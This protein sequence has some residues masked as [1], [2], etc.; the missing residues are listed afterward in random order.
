MRVF[1]PDLKRRLKTAAGLLWL[2]FAAAAGETLRRSGVPPRVW[3]EALRAWIGGFGPFGP[4]VYVLIFV[5]RPLTF[6]PATVMT[7]A[8]GLIW[9]PLGGTLFTLL[10]ENI[11]AGVAFWVAR[12]L[13]REWTAGLENA[14]LNRLARRL[15]GDEFRTVLLLRLFFAP[16]DMVN[17]ASGL[18]SMSYRSFAAATFVG[19][20]PGVIC[21][22]LL[23][24]SWRDPRLLAFSAGVLALGLGGARL[25]RVRETASP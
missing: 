16:F 17:F 21:F 8:S 1:S 11:S 19:I 6:L 13:G 18:T 5:V 2:A 9:G 12:F 10:G 23:G 14:V 3:P 4:A 22:V 7:V 24:S 20:I 15:S 25:M